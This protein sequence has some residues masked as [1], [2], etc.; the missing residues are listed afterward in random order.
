VKLARERGLRLLVSWMPDA[1]EDDPDNRR[2]ALANLLN[3][4]LDG[5]LRALAGE[6][7]AA[8]VPVLFRPMPEPNTPWYSWSGF[9]NGNTPDQ[10]VAAWRRVRSIVKRHGGLRVNMLWSP[11]VRSVPE[12]PENAIE[13]YFP[14]A[15]QVD[16]VGVSGYNFGNVGDLAWTT[17]KDLFVSAYA[18]IEALARK[19]FWITETASTAAGGEQAQW[20]SA[21]RSLRLDMPMLRGVVWFDVADP[22]GD[23]RLAGPALQAARSFLKGRCIV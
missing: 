2:Y 23:F 3:G 6:L 16:Y 7:K 20:V 15:G 14:G 22:T 13:K 11:Y 18:S 12:T 17:P 4:S 5:D 19:P 9:A 21:L 1:G 8:G 10:Y